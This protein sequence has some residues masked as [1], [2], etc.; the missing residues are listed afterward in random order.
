M[1]RLLSLLILVVS[2]VHC[3]VSNAPKLRSV[4]WLTQ[5]A[6]EIIEEYLE[7]TPHAKILEFGSGASTVWFAKRT[8]NLYSVEDNEKW[9]GIISNYLEEKNLKVNYFLRPRPYYSICDEFAEGF[10]DMILVDGR[11]RKGCIAHSLKLLKPGGTLVLDNSERK[12]Y[13]AVFPLL[14][15]WKS[16][17]TKQKGPD[18]EGFCYRGWETRFWTK[19]TM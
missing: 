13:F 1:K 19:P 4:P 11:N 14:D 16:I 15:S 9:H 3:S 5:R 12:R 6:I 2:V 8:P 17:I 18:S 10:F 7:R